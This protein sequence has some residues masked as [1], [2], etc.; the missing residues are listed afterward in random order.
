MVGK[1]L[2]FRGGRAMALVPFALFIVVTIGLSFA[3]FQDINAMVTA[4]MIALLIDMIFCR[5]LEDYWEVVLKGLGSKVAMTAVMLWL[6]VG[7]YGAISIVLFLI[8]GGSGGVI[9]PAEAE[10][11][12]SQYQR[13]MGLLLLIPTCVVIFMAVKGINIF[14][15]LGTGSALAIIIGLAAGLFKISDLIYLADE[16]VQGTITAGVAGMFNVSI[17]LM[18]V[19]AMGQILIAS[20]CMETVVDWLN[21]SVIKS[22][23]DAEISMFCLSTAFG[24]LIAAINTI[25]NI[26]VCTYIKEYSGRLSAFCGCAIAAGT[27]MACG[28]CYLKGGG[29]KEMEYVINNMAS[30]ITG[31]ICDGGNQG[32]TMKGVAACDTAFRSVEFALKGV[33]IDKVHGINGATAEDTMRNM[34][35]IASPGMVG[36][37]K[38]IVEIFEN[39]LR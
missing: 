37:E 1:K 17:L 23:R 34:G 16:K 28:I 20:G 9:D 7:M 12:L 11:L 36:T 38:T 32:C 5:S 14:A 27:G 24:I 8:F 3:N 26:C 18:L 35:L 4:G 19:V 2:E 39:K 15:C 25:A 10:T 13:P 21:N 6:V 31:M 33:H 30:S 29:L 22:E